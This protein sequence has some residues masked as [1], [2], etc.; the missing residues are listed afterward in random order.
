[1]CL[2]TK[3]FRGNNRTC[4]YKDNILLHN[5]VSTSC[6]QGTYNKYCKSQINSLRPEELLVQL[7]YIKQH[8]S[9]NIHKLALVLQHIS[10]EEILSDSC[11]QL[12]LH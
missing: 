3:R 11:K 8:L 2:V 10:V 4:P 6:Q 12:Q 7:F 1:M 9:I 5:V